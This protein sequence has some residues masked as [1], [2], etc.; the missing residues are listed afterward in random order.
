MTEPR[1]SLFVWITWLSKIMAGEQ[2]CV[3]ASWFKT[4]F[5][6]YDKAPTDF[7]LVTWTMEHTRLVHELHTERTNAGEQAFLEGENEIRF[8]VSNG[9]VLV[10]KPDLVTVSRTGTVI[11]DVKTGKEKMSDQVQVLLYMY[12]LPLG[13]SRH[14]G[15]K[16]SG[17]VVYKNK[18][19]QISAKA[20]DQSFIK[21]F[22]H[23]L[24]LVTADKP[25]VRTPRRNECRFCELTKSD[26]SE[27]VEC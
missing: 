8:Q 19:V 24:K 27:R 18:R 23:F 11:Y 1:D 2:S 9:A 5:K 6:N 3:W 26:C 22:E 21:N 7:D 13:T 12:L 10:G 25:A 4:H 16:P 14:V 17:C 20:V 15:C